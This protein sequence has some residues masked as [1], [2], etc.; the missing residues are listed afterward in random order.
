MRRGDASGYCTTEC[1]TDQDCLV[2]PECQAN[3]SACRPRGTLCSARGRCQAAE[4][5]DPPE[6]VTDGPVDVGAFEFIEGWDAAPGT[7]RF[8]V[9]SEL[10]VAPEGEGFDVD[11]LCRDTGDCVDNA[12]FRLGQLGND[13]I[14]QGLLGGETTLL[15]ELAGLDE[16]FTGHDQ[17]LTV[18]FYGG[19]DADVPPRPGNN[20]QIPPGEDDCCRFK[21]SSASLGPGGV[22]ARARAPAYIVGGVLRTL[23]PVPLDF[24][25]TVGVPPH[26]E[27]RIARS[28][29]T[30]R[31]PATL[32]RMSAGLIGGAIPIQ[33]L[34][35]IENPYCR[36]LN[37]LC[38]QVLSDS[39]LLDLVT[40]L[41]Q[42]DID[43]DVPTDGLERLELVGG[44]ARRCF[45]GDGTAVFPSTPGD[46]DWMCALAPQMADGYSVGLSF[47]AV[48]AYFAGVVD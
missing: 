19:R 3:P 12:L 31:L 11:G 38:P 24:R 21:I 22:Q 35:T 13:Q 5:E 20:F 10:A 4:P 25:L 39:T 34:V 16:P 18:K 45:D 46:P 7:G 40:T 48:R 28:R 37:Q 42:P 17:N 8:F 9:V 2:A 15:I 23:A 33:T 36:T 26:P 1:F 43:I 6:V 30:A 44:R 47:S 14:R 41:L 32:Q 27:V 29:I